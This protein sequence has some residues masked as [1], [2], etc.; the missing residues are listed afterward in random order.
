MKLTTK[1][2]FV[3]LCDDR[4]YRSKK[5]K[6]DPM[7]CGVYASKKE[8][9]DCAEEIKDCVL[10]HYIKQCKVTVEYK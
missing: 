10:D 3:L 5:E 2:F 8:A 1:D 9:Q 6:R 7:I 4:K